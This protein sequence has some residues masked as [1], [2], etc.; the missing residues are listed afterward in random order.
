MSEVIECLVCGNTTLTTSVKSE[1]FEKPTP[2]QLIET[3]ILFNEGVVD[4]EKL[5]DMISHT[6]FII[7]RLYENG[8]MRTPTAQE[9]EDEKSSS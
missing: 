5:A 6:K 8:N 4:K 7:D 2:T 1:R 3:A 9:I